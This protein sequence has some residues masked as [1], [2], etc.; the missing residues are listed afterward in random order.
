MNTKLTPQS[1]LPVRTDVRSGGYNGC[2]SYCSNNYSQCYADPNIPDKGVCN[3]RL[4]VCQN[5]CM[6][7]ATTP[8]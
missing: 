5:A 8:N 7:C 6:A 2:M 3:D 1:G 4:P